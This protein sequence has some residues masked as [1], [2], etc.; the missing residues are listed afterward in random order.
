MKRTHFSDSKDNIIGVK[1][2]NYIYYF[3]D[4]G[5]E[6]NVGRPGPPGPKGDP[7]LDGAPGLKGILTSNALKTVIIMTISFV[8][9]NLVSIMYLYCGFYFYLI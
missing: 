2:L 3:Q 8:L 5:F 6:S 9:I 1:I 7:G 4:I